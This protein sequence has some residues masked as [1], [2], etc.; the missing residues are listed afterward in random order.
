VYRPSKGNIGNM[1][2]IAIKSN[3]AIIFIDKKLLIN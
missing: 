3:N 2:I 1:K